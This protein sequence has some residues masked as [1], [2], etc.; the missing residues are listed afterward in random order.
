MIQ[1]DVELQLLWRRVVQ[2]GCYAPRNL[3]T[4]RLL[5]QKLNSNSS[6]TPIPKTFQFVVFSLG[7]GFEPFFCMP[8]AAVVVLK[9]K[10]EFFHARYELT[11]MHACHSSRKVTCYSS[12]ALG[13]PSGVIASTVLHMAMVLGCENTLL[14]ARRGTDASAHTSRGSSKDDKGTTCKCYN[15]LL[16]WCLNGLST[17][18][19]SSSCLQG[20][21]SLCNT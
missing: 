3:S 18:F 17:S 16:R 14:I 19:C 21:A 2:G 13:C 1:D 7:Y 15:R 11:T 10:D 8:P 6:W 5:V 12:T 20:Y 4:M 9:P